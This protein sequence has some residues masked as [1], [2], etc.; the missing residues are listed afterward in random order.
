M[1][2]ILIFALQ[3]A[4]GTAPVPFD[5]KGVEASSGHSRCEAGVGAE[6]TVCGSRNRERYRLPLPVER[7]A[8]DI[9][10]T[11][12]DGA[13]RAS[14]ETR[15]YAACGIFAGQRRCDNAESRLYGYGGGHDP[16][17]LLVKLGTRLIDENSDLVPPPPMPERPA[18]R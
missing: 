3:V 11:V 14:L 6:V 7:D 2:P 13:P 5:L 1:A 8:R 15:P 12:R 18:G 9:S 16:V 17:S 4:A 10:L